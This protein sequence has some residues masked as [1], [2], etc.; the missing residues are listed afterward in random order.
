MNAKYLK[1]IS[2]LAYVFIIYGLGFLWLNDAALVGVWM[3]LALVPMFIGAATQFIMDPKKQKAFITIGLLALA[4]T[5]LLLSFLLVVG[6][7]AVICVAMAAPIVAPLELLGVW[8]ARLMIDANDTSNKTYAALILLPLVLL[9]FEGTASFPK[10]LE[11]VVSE[12]IIDAPVDVVWDHTVVIPE[13]QPDE[14]IWTFSHALLRTPKP[15]SA[16]V[17]GDVRSL[18][19]SKGVL[20]K[21]IITGRVI[22]QRLAWRFDFYAPE[23]LAAFDPHISPNSRMLKVTDGF[24]ELKVLEDG[25]T[26]LRLETHYKIR[27]PFNSYVRLWGNIFLN[28]FH[29]SVLAVIKTR[30]EA[31]G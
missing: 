5:A 29:S 20:F 28:D 1:P 17:S 8:I 19:W 26:R 24:Y 31:Q 30:A 14:R 15:I 3:A 10:S 27:T 11:T 16:A 22:N 13:I 21:E 7:E 25:R 4:F 6:I 12:I 9:P 2:L 23:T 18:R